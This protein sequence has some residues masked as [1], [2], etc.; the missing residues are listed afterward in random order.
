MTQ[1]LADKVVRAHLREELGGPASAVREFAEM[2]LD[3]ARALAW[4]AD[5]IGAI[6][7]IAGTL[8]EAADQAVFGDGGDSRLLGG[9]DALHLAVERMLL[10]PDLPPRLA[11]GLRKVLAAAD[12]LRHTIDRQRRLPPEA[13]ATALFAGLVERL[14]PVA[15]TG[16]TGPAGRILVVDDHV[17]H[18]D[19]LRQR[20]ERDGHSVDAVGTG[21]TALERLAGG[22]FDLVL[23]DMVMPGIS[24]YELLHRIKEDEATRS[25]PVIMVSALDDMPSI[26]RCIEAGAEDYLP[27][28]SNPTLL[29]AR[30]GACLEKKRLR[31][32]ERTHLAAV[33]R[34]LNTA[35]EVQMGMLPEAVPAIA[36]IDGHGIVIPARDIGGDLYDWLQWPERP[37]HVGVAVGDVSGKSVPAAFFMAKAASLLRTTAAFGLTPGACLTQLNQTLCERNGRMMFVTLCYG[38][39][40]A[41][42][43]L[44]T[45]ANGGHTLPLVIP[46]NGPPRWVQRTGGCALGMVEGRVFGEATLQL[47]PGDTLLLYS[48][49]ITEAFDADGNI[50]GDERLLEAATLLNGLTPTAMVESLVA[51]VNAFAGKAPQSDDIA[52]VA[53]RWRG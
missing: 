3:D 42:T 25:L 37:N 30:V 26:A 4:R 10:E 1:G 14:T 13:P 12:E 23:L 16:A 36:G 35:R 29:R 19:V 8:A 39:L 53:L 21:Q 33:E 47:E 9:I 28:P 44:F 45:Y 7:A 34:D 15:A 38:V 2:L 49:G 32:V 46:A 43:G 52:C 48:D 5:E 17:H 18:R 31:D 50:F 27:K 11:E 51:T 40:D 24:G 6:G 41:G 20:L 22:G